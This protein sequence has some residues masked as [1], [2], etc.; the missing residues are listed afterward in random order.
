MGM[1]QFSDSTVM[2]EVVGYRSPQANDLMERI[3]TL[4]I[5]FQPDPAIPKP[6]LHWG[7][8]NHQL[9][10]SDLAATPLGQPYKG[11]LTRLDAFRTL[12]A[13]IRQNNAPVFDNN[14]TSR[15]GL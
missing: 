6:L 14:F 11:A 12:R 4:G 10:A 1:Q 9:T 5:A 7:L 8:E 13:F 2:V 3:Q 15:L